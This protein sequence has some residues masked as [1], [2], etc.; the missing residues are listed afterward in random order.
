MASIHFTARL[1]VPAEVAWDFL[2]RYTRSEV[3]M[4]SARLGATTPSR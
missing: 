1:D 3:H 4:F 2:E